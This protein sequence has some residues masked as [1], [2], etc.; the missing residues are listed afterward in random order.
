MSTIEGLH[1]ISLATGFCSG[2]GEAQDQYA[3]ELSTPNLQLDNALIQVYNNSYV[4][5]LMSKELDM[6]Y[7]PQQENSG[8]HFCETVN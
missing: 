2:F 7:P 8:R 4:K 3:R 5:L 6:K 1:C